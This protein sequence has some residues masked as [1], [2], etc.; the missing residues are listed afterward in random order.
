MA[1]THWPEPRPGQGL[2]TNGLYETEQ[3]LPTKTGQV[4]RSIVSH[5]SGSDPCSSLGPG[6]TQ[7][8]YRKGKVTTQN[9]KY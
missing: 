8:H 2:G 7:C 3:E 6:S 1:Y 9:N 4:L 5:Y